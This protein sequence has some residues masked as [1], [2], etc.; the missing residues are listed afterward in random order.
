[1]FAAV[2][3]VAFAVVPA[4]ASHPEDGQ[5]QTPAAAGDESIESGAVIRDGVRVV[6]D[7]ETGEIVARSPRIGKGALSDQLANALSRS[8]EGLEVFD[9]ANDGKGFALD[10]RFQHVF[11]V[12]LR[13]DGS[14]E[15]VCVNHQHQA[16]K[17]LQP[18]NRANGLE[19]AVK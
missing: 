2:A 12:R 6:I 1:L 13:P 10:S 4:A 15:M 7:P 18:Q 5:R 17:F 11:M 3:A 14:F 19:R 9:L 8:T 16:E